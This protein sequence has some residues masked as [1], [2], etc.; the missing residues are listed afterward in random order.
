[1]TLSEIVNEYWFHPDD[2]FLQYNQVR[3][4]AVHG[5]TKRKQ[6]LE[7]MLLSLVRHAFG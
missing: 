5:F 6:L 7:L 1:M 2:T 3:S 4:Y